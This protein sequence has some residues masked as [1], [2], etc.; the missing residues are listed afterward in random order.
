MRRMTG[1]TVAALLLAGTLM[2]ASAGTASAKLHCQK[3][4]PGGGGGG[5]IVLITPG[6][7]SVGPTETGFVIDITSAGISVTAGGDNIVIDV[8]GAGIVIDVTGAGI[9]ERSITRPG[10]VIDVTAAG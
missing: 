10:I 6:D 3:L 2:V 9:V 7:R 5:A 8:T 1:T 4:C